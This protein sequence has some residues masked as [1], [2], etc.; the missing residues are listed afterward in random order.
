MLSEFKC[1]KTINS[2]T[3][4]SKIKQQNK[5]IA[6][7]FVVIIILSISF[8]SVEAATVEVE[9]TGAVKTITVFPSETLDSYKNHENISRDF[10]RNQLFYDTW[11]LIKNYNSKSKKITKYLSTLDSDDSNQNNKTNRNKATSLSSKWDALYS[12]ILYLDGEIEK[13]CF[14]SG[15]GKN[16]TWDD[17]S[18]VTNQDYSNMRKEITSCNNTLNSLFNDIKKG[19]N[20]RKTADVQ[21]VTKDSDKIVNQNYSLV[22]KLWIYLGK[23][24]K[25][26]GRDNSQVDSFLGISWSTANMKKIANTIAPVT[27][28]FAY[29]IVII[30]FAL[31]IQNTMLQFDIMTPRGIFKA[32]GNLLIAKVWVDLSITVCA[33]ILQIVNSMNRQILKRLVADANGTLSLINTSNVNTSVDNSWWDFIGAI[34]NFFTAWLWVL[35]ELLL[36]ITLGI[37][38]I[39]VFIKIITR[40]FELT[41]LL[42]VAPL[43]FSTVVNE[44]TKV[45]FKKFMGAFLSTAL[46]MT[47][48]VICYIVGT[49]W[50]AEANSL[51]TSSFSGYLKDMMLL[52]PRFIIIF[53][54]CKIMR[55][56]PKVLTNLLD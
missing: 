22:N 49:Q 18:K 53:G 37:S 39:G 8:A 2:I 29:C 33:E 34:I 28:S 46:Y 3:I 1:P 24:L 44:E 54:I 23:T 35:P 55:K 19:Y 27:K 14:S 31:N 56:P 7:F 17:G 38:I 45:Y 42:A 40:Q 5:L 50:L 13:T 30:L 4:K 26:F 25:N 48:M 16:I 6:L 11:N 36:V 15:T 20:V 32:F 43:A 41:C 52:I 47:F 12:D 10:L 9:S 21:S 51:N